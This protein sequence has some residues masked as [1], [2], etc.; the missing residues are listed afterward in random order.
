MVY[1][2]VRVCDCLGEKL[3]GSRDSFARVSHYR[4][5]TEKICANKVP[6][7]QA[8]YNPTVLDFIR[9]FRSS[10]YSN[11]CKWLCA[12][13]CVLCVSSL[14][15]FGFLH[16]HPFGLCACIFHTHTCYTRRIALLP[17]LIDSLSLQ[18]C[19][20]VCAGRSYDDDV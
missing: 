12:V 1:V 16:R 5:I 14:F 10:L 17:L 15:R 11:A 18:L 13:C 7:S 19:A 20:C 2:C 9:H 8:S 6:Y 3:D 4:T